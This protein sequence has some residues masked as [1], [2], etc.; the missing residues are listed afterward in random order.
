MKRHISNNLM[1]KSRINNRF[2]GRF[3][4]L[5]ALILIAVLGASV[6]TDLF[7]KT[8]A[9]GIANSVIVEL[10]DDPAAVWKAKT[11]KEQVVGLRR[12][13]A[14][15]PQFAEARQDQFFSNRFKRKA[16]VTKL[17]A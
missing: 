1:Q 4:F 10:K 2:L 3:T 7:S 16:S 6:F 11:E 15:L 9:S 13:V 14:E 8:D 17:T 5:S 12:A